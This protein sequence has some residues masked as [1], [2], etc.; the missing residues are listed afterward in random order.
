MVADVRAMSA[1][2]ARKALLAWALSAMLGGF[3]FGY[4]LAVISGALLFVRQDLGLS[5]LQ[6]GA[7]VSAV[8]LGAM[9]GGVLA[10]WAAGA[11]GRR[12]AL[13]LIAVL[14]IAG[15]VLAVAAPS[16]AVLLGARGVTGVAVGAVS[17]AAPLYLSEIAPPAERGR[18][19]TLNQLMV[20]LGIVVAY[21]V[22]LAFSGSGDWRAMFGVG[23]VPS[24]LLLAGML[25]APETPAWLESHGETE[26]ARQVLAKVVGDAQAERLLEDLRRGRAQ[27]PRRVGVRTLLRSR[28]APALLIGVTL[29]TVQQFAGINAVI[30][31]APSIMERTGLSASNSILYSILVGVVN[32]A[33]TVVAVRLVD[34]H[35]RR[36]LLLASTAGTGASLLLL[37]LTFEVPLGDWGSWLSL[38]GLLAYIASFAVGLGP[39]FWLLIAEIFPAEARGAGAGVSTAVNWFSSFVVGLLFVPLADA[40]GQGPTFWIFAAACAV[41]V[42]FVKRYVPE[43]QGRTFAD[44]EADLHARFERA[45]VHE[46]AR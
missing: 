4:E 17:S 12:R 10:G 23:L 18:L 9:L 25:R 24:G 45:A 31:Y 33:A 26:R 5:G 41:G 3:V 1:W 29:G 38:I 30:A 13:I 6:Q 34:R 21:C 35:G 7:L 15:T 8:P 44:I 42:L 19:V 43:T 11:L 14:F 28:A 2:Q 22:G 16:Y 32:V 36:P 37:G 46:P 39:I 20:T 40:V 27:S